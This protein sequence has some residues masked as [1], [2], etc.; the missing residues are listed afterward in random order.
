MLFEIALT[1]NPLAFE[2]FGEVYEPTCASAFAGGL[3]SSITV[4]AVVVKTR[5]RTDNPH[6]Q[7]TNLAALCE[8][9]LYPG[10][11][12][13]Y[14]PLADSGGC[15]LA[16]VGA[17]LCCLLIFFQLREM[18][19]ALRGALTHPKVNGPLPSLGTLH[20]RNG[21]KLG[22]S[23]SLSTLF[24]VMTLSSGVAE[25]YEEAMEELQMTISNSRFSY[26]H[27]N[28]EFPLLQYLG[29]ASLMLEGFT[30]LLTSSPD[31]FC[32]RPSQMSIQVQ[33]GAEKE[34]VSEE[35][36]PTL[37][38]G[39]GCRDVKTPYL[40]INRRSD[41]SLNSLGC[42]GFSSPILSPLT[43]GNISL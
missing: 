29:K 22:S 26:L 13:L 39:Q 38:E 17:W 23:Y 11:V 10:I 30:A 19:V 25:L 15:R 34:L 8:S 7:E 2:G 3:S 16:G 32:A 31:L 27:T 43:S 4:W 14:V 21:K 36:V 35:W 9:A 37:I 6:T 20:L 42:S 12:T 28:H 18:L 24:S 1:V 40:P 41:T 33:P 5:I